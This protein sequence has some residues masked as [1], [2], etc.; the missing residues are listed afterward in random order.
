MFNSIGF[1]NIKYSII[2]IKDICKYNNIYSILN[3]ELNKEKLNTL[4]NSMFFKFNPVTPLYFVFFKNQTYIIDGLHRLEIYKKN[5]TLHNEN[6]PIVEIFTDNEHDITN[7]YNLINNTNINLINEIKDI[8]MKEIN[9]IDNNQISNKIDNNIIIKDTYNYFIKHFPNTFKFNGKRRPYL[10]NIL[11]KEHLNIIYKKN[12]INSSNDFID[13]LLNLNN[14]YKSKDLEWYPSKGKIN[15]Q[16][17]L[18]IINKDNCLYFGMLPNKWYNNIYKLP[19]INSEIKISQSLRQQVWN[20]YAKNKLKIKCICCN[21]NIISAFTFEC[22]HILAS[23]KGGKCNIKNL[24]PICS[25]C[26]KSMGNTNMK[27]FIINHNYK[28][29]KILK[30]N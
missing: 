4:N 2:K 26:N 5:S 28:M 29:N 9:E 30:L 16:K 12:N 7:Y 20:K 19:E 13:K 15:N 10:D 6:I 8:E 25:L 22:G 27:E 1:K 18:E 3:K 14:K 23:S 21:L 17:L 24:V 11:F